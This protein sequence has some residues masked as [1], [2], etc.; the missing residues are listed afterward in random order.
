[1]DSVQGSFAPIGVVPEV[2][3]LNPLAPVH[4]QPQAPRPSSGRKALPIDFVVKDDGDFSAGPGEFIPIPKTMMKFMTDVHGP[5]LFFVQAVF[6][7]T[8]YPARND[9]LGLLVDGV[10]YPLGEN[11]IFSD[12][13]GVGLLKFGGPAQWAMNLAPG[14]HTAQVLLRGGRDEG[15]VKI[16]LSVPC[17]VKANHKCPLVLSSIHS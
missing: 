6:A 1:M 13:P 3:V 4:L 7:W 9:H 17:K 11:E 14:E 5:A 2:H 12:A 16:G 15:D 8:G 10:V